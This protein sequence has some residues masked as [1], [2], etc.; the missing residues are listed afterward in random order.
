MKNFIHVL[1]LYF[2]RIADENLEKYNIGLGI[3]TMQGFEKR[4]KESKNVLWR[5]SN[6]NDNI[7]VRN[8]KQLWDIFMKELIFDIIN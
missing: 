7:I 6:G 4:N 1:R 5:F 3:F 8:I 2:S